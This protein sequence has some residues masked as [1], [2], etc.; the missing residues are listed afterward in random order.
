MSGTGNSVQAN[1]ANRLEQLDEIA[2][3]SLLYDF[4]GELLTKRQREVMELYHGENLSLAEIASEFGI[5]RQ[6][7]HDALRNARK[8]LDG[9]EEKLGL[10]RRFL[11]TEDAIR[12]VDSEILTVIG[13]L[14]GEGAGAEPERNTERGEV[15][16]AAQN[17]DAGTGPNAAQN[18]GVGAEPHIGQNPGVGAEIHATQHPGATTDLIRRL[19]RIR[20]IIDQLEE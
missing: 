17:P 5:S 19:N 7:V 4:Y 3:Q 14:Q 11:K 9:Y 1:E 12:R 2:R 20:A 13:Q 16:E 6:G 18:P 15:A 8:A 10:V